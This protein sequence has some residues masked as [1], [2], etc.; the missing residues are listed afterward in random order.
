MV[1]QTD[2]SENLSEQEVRTELDRLLR[3]ALF[4]QSDRLA[5]FLRFAIE[6]ALAGNTDLLKEYVIG[7]EVYDRKPPYHP[8]QDSIVRTEARRLRAK[9]K[10]YYESEGK[11]DPVF[12]YFRPGTYV[13]LFRRNE[14]IAA[15]S[16][17]GTSA[18]SELLVQGVGVGVAVLPFIDLSNRPRS[19][20]CAKGVTEELIHS[21]SRADGIRVIAR[22][23]APQLVEAPQDIPSLSQKYGLSTVI[24]GTVREDFDRLR[25]T[26]RVLGSDGFQLSSHRFDT[27]ASGEAMAQV[28]ERIASAFVSRARPEQ[29]RVR[30]RKAAPSA[31]TMAVYPLVLHAETLLD[32][33]SVSD[34]PA[35]LAK[36]QEAREVAPA[37]ARAW[38]GISHCNLEMALRGAS[39][40][41]TLILT[42]KQAAQRAIELDP[43]MIESYSCLGGAQALE[44]DWVNAEKNFLHGMEL[45]THA[46]AAR[47]YGLFLTSLGRFDEASH[48]FATAQQIDP[49]SNR[50]KVARAKFMHLTRRYDEGL[51]PLS[52]PLMYGPLPVEAR[53]LLAL[54]AAHQGDKE[55]AKQLVES[56]RPDSAAQLPMMAGIAEVLALT[57]ER[58]EANQIARAFRLLSVDTAISRFRQALLSLALEDKAGALSFL[59]L[60]VEEHEAELAWLGVEP[61]FD[62]IRKMS[63]FEA[64]V[65]TVVPS[66]AG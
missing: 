42:A 63:A 48:H 47:R 44:W 30:R 60:S 22:P 25:I 43:D 24:E 17:D 32:E 40:S 41:R 37:Y 58:E 6:N 61:R 53:G 51:R 21:L 59:R 15:A 45:G 14:S 20:L 11:Q 28:Q 34:L 4:L 54:M 9:L 57:G 18:E 5:R 39:P 29:S 27:E 65:S 12:I 8:S 3:S 52:R 33:G 35:S 13:P 56:I 62:P 49:F 19:A 46:S 23:S 66:F 31:L 10:E 50:Q 1:E 38:V 55:R 26:V 16:P 36:F 64:L 7:T 2:T